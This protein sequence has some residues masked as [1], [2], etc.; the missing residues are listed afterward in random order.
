[1]LL[2]IELLSSKDHFSLHFQPLPEGIET[3]NPERF[4][5]IGADILMPVLDCI[6]SRAA[7]SEMTSRAGSAIVFAMSFPVSFSST[8]KYPL[9]FQL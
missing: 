5:S 9:I 2:T 3:D 4:S 6:T 1:M 8:I 7:S